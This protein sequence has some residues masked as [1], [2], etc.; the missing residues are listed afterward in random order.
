MRH[1]EFVKTKTNKV[2]SIVW[3]CDYRFTKGFSRKPARHVKPTLVEIRPSDEGKRNTYYSHTVYIPYKK[4]GDLNLNKQVNPFDNTG[5]RMYTG[6]DIQ[7]FLT[8]KECKKYYS[9]LCKSY[10]PLIEQEIEDSTKGLRDLIG[11][12]KSVC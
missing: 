8:E 5:H 10:I 6:I 2:G 1:K 7:V 9:D 11:E 4:N 12:L 3:V